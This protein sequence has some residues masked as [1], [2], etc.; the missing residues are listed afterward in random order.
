MIDWM[1]FLVVGVAS[2]VGASTLV[3]TAS[4][5]I[6]LLENGTKEHEA[7]PRAG[8]T[9]LLGA[10]ALFVLCGV[11]VIYGVYLIVPFFH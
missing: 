6:R 11:L 5:G 2:L 10:W 9:A 8:R 7:D 3:A 1:S 4:L